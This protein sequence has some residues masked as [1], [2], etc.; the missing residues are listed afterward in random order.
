MDLATWQ[1]LVEQI[2]FG[3]R[4]PQAVYVHV[5]GLLRLDPALLAMLGQVQRRFALDEEP[6][7]L[8]KFAHR[9]LRLSLLHYPD[10]EED[11]HPALARAVTV[12]LAMGK[13]ERRDYRESR[14]PP[15]LHRKEAFLP[16]GDHRAH[17]WL[18]LT[19][20]EEAAGL[21]ANT[22]VIGT[23]E[24]W[25]TVLRERGVSHV[26]HRL[27]RVAAP[28]VP[29][30]DTRA[31]A[32]RGNRWRTALSRF[33]L[34]TPVQAL[35]RFDLLRVEHRFLDYG[36]GQGD[37][38]RALRELGH[39]A[40]GWDPHFAP[41]G[42]KREADIVNLGFVINV[43]ENP[44]ERAQVLQEAF[45]LARLAV[46]VGVMLVRE[47]VFE[48][49]TPYGD[50]VV[51]GLGTF[52]RYFEQVELCAYI[53][54][55]LSVEPLVLGPGVVTAFRDPAEL[56]AFLQ[57]RSR[58]TIDFTALSARI[59]AD[60]P[61]R[62][63]ALSAQERNQR[64]YDAHRELFED[65]WAFLAKLGR[66]PP[67]EEYPRSPEL[68]AIGFTL[69]RARALY[70]RMFGEQALDDAF[71]ERNR[72]VLDAFRACLEHLGRCPRLGEFS[73]AT[74]LEAI[75]LS[76]GKAYNLHVRRFGR[77]SIREG[78]LR[79]HQ[80]LL[81]HC[82]QT[83][84][85]WGRIPKPSEYQRRTE[86][87][88]I[89][90]SLADVHGLFLERFGEETLVQARAIRRNDL[91]VYLALANF[92]KRVP[93][94]D[95]PDRLRNDLVTFFA[96]YTAAVEEAIA[97][98][99]QAGDADRIAGLCDACRDGVI[100]DQ[101]L[102]LHT[103][104]VANLDPVLRIYIGCAEVL[105]GDVRS[106]DILKLH[107]RSGKLTLLC[108]DDFEGRRLPSL[109][110]RVKVLLKGQ[111]LQEFDYSAGAETQV[112]YGKEQYVGQD[113]PKRETWASWSRKL[114]RLIGPIIERGP[115]RET[116]QRQLAELGYDLQLRP[117]SKSEDDPKET[118]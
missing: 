22:S 29:P 23:R 69:P 16:P 13:I 49:T 71:L 10:F 81:D 55:V 9:E 17:D 64:L 74:E 48:G 111:R 100:D 118:C 83:F 50:G 97:L 1:Q 95:L 112:L 108:Y 33:G 11:P 77:A 106:A 109:E 84:V 6:S 45:G 78:F 32:L 76:L 107:K 110:R 37:D 53:E 40:E 2:P 4:L 52:Q 79:Q 73:S 92:R 34:S 90:L 15:I 105:C 31:D 41:D 43:I 56:Q 93:F 89:G 67:P 96:T 88:G 104:L 38:V 75:G 46:V 28:S 30:A 113:H 82:W 57:R 62:Q 80:E 21:Y 70:V 20:Q 85:D 8:L 94:K 101:A 65:F 26:G 91:L 58:R 117:L 25:L 39:Q 3:K 115:S 7:T 99:Y 36:C 103:S 35:L 86:L 27:E 5:D 24:G 61:R 59:F 14:N 114:E 42:L 44:A 60:K 102:Y 63:P 66:T 72:E 116:L 47:R 54:S 51:S 68:G 98:L 12:D 87:H 18:S 19:H